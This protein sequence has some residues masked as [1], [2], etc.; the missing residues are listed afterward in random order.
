MNCPGSVL[1][2][3]DLPDHSSPYAIEG[4]AAHTLADWCLKEQAPTSVFKGR[5][6]EVDT[7]DGVEKVVVDPSMVKYVQEYLDYVNQF[8]GD[9]YSEVRVAYTNWVENGYGTSDHVAISD[10]LCRVTD[11]KYGKGVK[12][13]AAGNTQ[14]RLYALGVYQE[15]SHLYDF[16]EFVLAIHQPRLHHVDEERITLSELLGWAESEV[17]P[18]GVMALEPDAPLAAGKWCT[19]C[20]ARDFCKT[21]MEYNLAQVQDDFTDLGSINQSPLLDPKTVSNDQLAELL[22]IVPELKK[23]CTDLESRAYEQIAAGHAVGDWKLVAG[24]RSRKWKSPAEAEKALRGTAL[25]VRDFLP[26]KLISPAQAEKL[27]EAPIFSALAED[28]IV[29]TSGKPTLA[30]GDDPRDS[31][32]LKPEEEFADVD[33]T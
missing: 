4:T 15:F 29:W 26:P 18:A 25:K 33:S 6:I 16:D 2:T 22:H 31:Y 9:H 8:D 27:L 1:L 12:V 20:K 21:R 7:E 5:T 23:L 30:P 3:K 24:R 32:E 28:V 11:L 19:F 10:G 13:F 17:R 14:A